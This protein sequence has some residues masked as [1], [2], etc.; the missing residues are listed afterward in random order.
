MYF[1]RLGPDG[2]HRW[3]L[4][5]GSAGNDA[6]RGIMPDG[7]GNVAAAGYISGPVD[8]AGTTMPHGG[9]EDALILSIEELP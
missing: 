8:I 4:A 5:L 9:G 2:E 3:S 7:H 1:A 6:V